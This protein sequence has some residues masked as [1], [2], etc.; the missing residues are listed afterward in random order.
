M[1]A[2]TEQVVNRA[3]EQFAAARDRHPEFEGKTGAITLFNE[4]QFYLLGPEDLRT[5]L[6]TS[7]GFELPEQ[8]GPVSRERTDLYDQDVLACI[9]GEHVSRPGGLP[10]PDSSTRRASRTRPGQA[11]GM[12]GTRRT[13]LALLPAALLSLTGGSGGS[14][15][16]PGRRRFRRAATGSSRRNR[17][18]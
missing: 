10:T 16:R 9:G 1:E 14:R 3:E 5:L 7:L 6:F 13:T 4:G 8:A 17:R 12:L 18:R 15:L 2:R 11:T